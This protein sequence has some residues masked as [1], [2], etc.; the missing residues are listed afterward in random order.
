MMPEGVIRA[1]TQT[2]RGPATGA[3]VVWKAGW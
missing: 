3:L 1:L 2:H